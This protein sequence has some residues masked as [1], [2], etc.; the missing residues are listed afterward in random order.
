MGQIVKYIAKHTQKLLQQYRYLSVFRLMM[1]IDR[2]ITYRKKT[3]IN[4]YYK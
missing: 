2:D 1:K 4:L 3:L